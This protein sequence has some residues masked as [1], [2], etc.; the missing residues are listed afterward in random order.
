MKFDPNGGTLCDLAVAGTQWVLADPSDVI[1]QWDSFEVV[2]R[3]ATREYRKPYLD[4]YDVSVAL[5]LVGIDHFTRPN[6]QKALDEL[7]HWFS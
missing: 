2:F 7:E 3:S 1:S 4:I 5:L 6:I